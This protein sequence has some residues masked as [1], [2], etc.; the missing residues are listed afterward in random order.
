MPLSPQF[1]AYVLDQ[2]GQVA[3]ITPKRMFGGIGVYAQDA[4]F[5]ILQ[6]DTVYLRVDDDNRGDYEAAGMPPFKPYADR[7]TVMPYRELPVEV[8]EDVD[9]LRR[10]V[11]A[12]IRAARRARKTQS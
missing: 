9:E 6:R 1:E 7:P 2:L 10:W 8:L 11:G 5:A 3:R 4:H 12:A